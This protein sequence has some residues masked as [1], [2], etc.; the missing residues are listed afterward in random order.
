MG[1]FVAKAIDYD[2]HDHVPRGATFGSRPLPPLVA[3]PNRAKLALEFVTQHFAVV[4]ALA[5]VAVFFCTTVSLY[6]YLSAFDWRLI[7]I[8]EYSDVF[9][10]SFI[11]LALISSLAITLYALMSA[12][13]LFSSNLS[14]HELLLSASIA[15][16]IC[17]FA[18]ILIAWLISGEF[19]AEAG[20][21]WLM[22]SMT[23]INITNSVRAYPNISAGGVIL[24][25]GLI[26]LTA[27]TFGRAFASPSI[28][29]G[30]V[31]YDITLKNEKLED[32]GLVM[33][34]SHHTILYTDK[35]AIVVPTAEVM[36]MQARST[37]RPK[38]E[39][40]AAEAC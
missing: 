38:I 35:K 32:M 12:F 16:V 8:V 37:T 10:A 30:G 36:R 18:Y 11:A 24:C 22:M 19:Q 1:E 40:T 31:R 34:T 4:S 14:S 27:S 5:A 2:E 7:W 26:L 17:G 3:N 13:M 39:C 15:M 23:V 28:G 29:M 33:V 20:M 6:S 9:K 25:G 21:F